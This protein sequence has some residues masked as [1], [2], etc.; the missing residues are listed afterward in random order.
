[1]FGRKFSQK[2]IRW[3][4]TLPEDLMTT[5]KEES[6]KRLKANSAIGEKTWKAYARD[7][8]CICIDLEMQK[9]RSMTDEEYKEAVKK[10]MR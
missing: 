5:L 7:M 4:L 9:I 3:S 6:L 8:V 10:S 1:M 2:M